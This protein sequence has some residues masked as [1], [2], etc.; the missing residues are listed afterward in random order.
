MRLAEVQRMFRFRLVAFVT[1]LVLSVLAGTASSRRP[2]LHRSHSVERLLPRLAP[3]VRH[4]ARAT[5][6]LVVAKQ[7]QD[8]EVTVG[9]GTGFVVSGPDATG[10]ALIMT[11]EH[12][13]QGAKGQF[14]AIPAEG[15]P[16][17]SQTRVVAS[18][19]KLDY[20]LLEVTL[21]AGN[22]IQPVTLAGAATA[23]T[24]DVYSIGH[25]AVHQLPPRRLGG[26]PRSWQRTTAAT[27]APV[28]A[29]PMMAE[30]DALAR[31]PQLIALGSGNRAAVAKQSRE[32]NTAYFDVPGAPGASE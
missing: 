20:A 9:H 19:K 3:R 10:R 30:A 25:P 29:N 21:P 1:C 22:G 6:P 5:M 31:S 12:V 26:S 17:R 13:V 16:Q 7:R 27:R 8:N 24:R 14:A 11:N 4:N 15:G 18:S 2:T 32:A 23:Q 28:G